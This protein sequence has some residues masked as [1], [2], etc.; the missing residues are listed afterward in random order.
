MWPDGGSRLHEVI[1]VFPA[2]AAGL[3]IPQADRHQGTRRKRIPARHCLL[4]I[5]VRCNACS[6]L[7]AC[8]P[9]NMPTCHPYTLKTIA[10]DVLLI[11]SDF[12]RDKHSMTTHV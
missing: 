12:L 4:L 9:V 2:L 8:Q 5:S 1:G 10:S 7:L 3:L 6:I 11:G